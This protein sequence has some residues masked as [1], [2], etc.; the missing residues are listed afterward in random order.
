[1]EFAVML[2]DRYML[3]VLF[4]IYLQSGLNKPACRQAGKADQQNIRF[5]VL[6]LLSIGLG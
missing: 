6:I 1:M 3:I 2:A 4:A 5:T